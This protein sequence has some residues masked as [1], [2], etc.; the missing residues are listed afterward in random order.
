MYRVEALDVFQETV[1]H[2]P[3]FMAKDNMYKTDLAARVN[4][5]DSSSQRR[6]R[7]RKHRAS[8]GLHIAQV[9]GCV[10]G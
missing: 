5:A 9:C 4:F 7:A 6:R 8:A 2:I 3:A 1:K 10:S